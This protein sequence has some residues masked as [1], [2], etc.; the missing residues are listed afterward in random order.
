MNPTTSS[1]PTST[2]GPRVGHYG[3]CGQRAFCFR[4]ACRRSFGDYKTLEFLDTGRII[5]YCH[6]L[7]Y[8]AGDPLLWWIA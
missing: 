1:K 7:T 8:V 6:G 3:P 5:A 4:S 2:L